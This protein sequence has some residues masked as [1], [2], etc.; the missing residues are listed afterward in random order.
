M[1]SYVISIFIVIIIVIIVSIVSIFNV[2]SK[3]FNN[4]KLYL[5]VIYY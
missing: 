1:N 3:H 2:I 4:V 5:L